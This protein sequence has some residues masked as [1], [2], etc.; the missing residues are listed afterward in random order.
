MSTN[1]E[2]ARRKYAEKWGTPLEEADEPPQDE[3]LVETNWSD[4]GPS[5]ESRYY[6]R[7]PE[8]APKPAPKRE[9]VKTVQIAPGTYLEDYL[10]K[11][12]EQAKTLAEN[13]ARL[14]EKL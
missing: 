14:Q 2:T 12:L 1:F 9:I 4:P 10:P 13:H 8:R 7:H 11:L 6:L 5:M 3:P